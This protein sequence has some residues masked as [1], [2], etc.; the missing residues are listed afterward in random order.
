[1]T[2]KSEKILTP[3]QALM[4]IRSLE[5]SFIGDRQGLHSEINKIIS[6]VKYEDTEKIMKMS[7]TIVYGTRN[8]LTSVQLADLFEVQRKI[9]NKNFERN[10][11][12]YEEG[13]H[14]IL[15]TGQQLK[16]FKRLHQQNE[17]L[18]FVSKLYLWTKEGAVLMAKSCISN[19]AWEV[20]DSKLDEIYN[21]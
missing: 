17:S 15:L 5:Y 13:N 8:V 11:E 10:K 19:N 20:L 3:A 7:E 21:N 4:K 12:R 16:D 14:Y 1:M 2:K 18:K 9:I 6:K